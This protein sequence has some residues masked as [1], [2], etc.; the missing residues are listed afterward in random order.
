MCILDKAI[1]CRV[2]LAGLLLSIFIYQSSAL[3]EPTLIVNANIIDGSG[4]AARKG[5]VRINN[6]QIIDVGHIVPGPNDK[7]I[8]AGGLILAP[9]FIDTHSHHDEDLEANPDALPLLTQGITTS[10]FGQDGFHQL[11]LANM[12]ERFMQNPASVN[13][14]SYAGHN[15]IR[16]QVMGEAANSAATEDQLAAMR[17]LLQ[18]ELSTG[19]LGLSTGLEYEPGLYSNKEE[20]IGLAVAA[21]EMGGRYISHIRSEDR[22]LWQALDEIIEVGRV[23]GMPVQ[24]SHLKLAAK[25]LWGKTSKLIGKLESARVQGVDISADI[26]PYEYWQSTIWVLLPD[27]DPDNLEEIARVLDSLTPADGIIFTQFEP[28]PNYVNKSVEEIAQLRNTEPARTLSDLM[29]EARAWSEAHGGREAESILG[30]SMSERDIK[31]LLTWQH[32]NLCSDGGFTGHPRGHGAFPRVLARYVRDQNLLSMENAIEMM[33]S[34]AAAHMGFSDR[35]EIRKGYKADLV[36][37]DP[38]RIQDHADIR[39]GQQ[40]S[41]GVEKVWVNGQLVLSNGRATGVRSGQ[42]IT[43][44]P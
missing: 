23:T 1:Y 10:V 20:V 18:Q 22:F 38:D 7:V 43:R 2:T 32:I 12:F 42:L 36:L 26:Y 16:A 28:N 11:P 33:T 19:A 6:A 5:A 3:A 39:N 17:T 35:G 27:R 13:I 24:I 40:L 9:G 8:D 14:A 21:A 41:T 15:S 30:R 25:D 31:T 29:K 44:E 4:S 34:R 37:F